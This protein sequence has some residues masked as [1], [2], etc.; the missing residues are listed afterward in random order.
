[1]G[2]FWGGRIVSNFRFIFPMRRAFDF[3]FRREFLFCIISRGGRFGEGKINVE[4]PNF[5]F[6][7]DGDF[8]FFREGFW[9]FVLAR[10]VD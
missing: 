8:H 3:F 4:F 9:M 2:V 1:M 7:C 6:L 10:A 5:L